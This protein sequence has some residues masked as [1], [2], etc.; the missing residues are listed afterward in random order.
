MDTSNPFSNLFEG[1]KSPQS[2]G[3]EQPPKT[4]NI[5]DQKINA[6]IENIFFITINRTSQKNKQRVFMED[7]SSAYPSTTLMNIDLLEQALFERILMANPRDYLIPN[8]TQNDDSD[9]V[10]EGKVIIYLYNCYERLIKWTRHDN[11]NVTI[12]NECEIMKQLIQ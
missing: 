4:L 2:K 10:A 7:L 5:M 8:N 3:T 12:Q 1:D 11:N 6:L 9:A